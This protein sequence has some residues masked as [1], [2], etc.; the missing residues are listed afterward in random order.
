MIRIASRFV[1]IAAPWGAFGFLNHGSIAIVAPPGVVIT[2]AA[3]PHQ[4]TWV[5]PAPAFGA[6]VCDCANAIEA[7]SSAAAIID[8]FIGYPSV[9][10]VEKTP[11]A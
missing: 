6:A 11:R 1:G 10:A 3:W 9:T 5:L 7:Q 8:R 2:N 4:V